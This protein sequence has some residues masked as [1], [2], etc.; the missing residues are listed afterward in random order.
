ML[1]ELYAKR[2]P[3]E[4]KDKGSFFTPPDVA[5]FMGMWA[6]AESSSDEPFNLLEP[7]AGSGGVMLAAADMF[8]RQGRDFK[9]LH[10]VAY[11]A[12]LTACHC[13]YVNTTVWEIPCLVR[14][15]SF[16]GDVFEDWPTMSLLKAL[17]EKAG[18]EPGF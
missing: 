5:N 12:D 11:D 14:Y 1:G 9:H 10:V 3:I 18:G 7:S 8:M 6:I 17:E 4:R 16:E 15:G 2:S 13:A